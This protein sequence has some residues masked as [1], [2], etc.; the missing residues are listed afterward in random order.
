MK[1]TV[2]NNMKDLF[3]W[4][5]RPFYR[6]LLLP[7]NKWFFERERRPLIIYHKSK[8]NFGL[9]CTNAANRKVFNVCTTQNA[10]ERNFRHFCRMEMFISLEN[11]CQNE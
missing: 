7:L 6:V 9:K 2:G 4:Y 8:Q 5:E 3:G 10:F 1:H 11:E